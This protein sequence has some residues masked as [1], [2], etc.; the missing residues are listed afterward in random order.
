MSRFIKFLVIWP[1]PIHWP[2]QPSTHPPMDG[3]VSTNHKSS[4]RIELSQLGQDLFDLIPPIDPPI[5]PWVGVS[6]Q[7]IKLQTELNYLDWVNILKNFNALNLTPPIN[8]P[9]HQIIHPPMGGGF[10]TDFKSSNRIELSWL[11]QV[12]LNFYWFRWYPMGGGRWVD[13][14]RDGYGC[15]GGVPCIHTCTCTYACTC[16]L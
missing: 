7:I 11:V 3:G 2:T 10:S 4:N 13:W 14:G 5:H 8:P 16:M 1:D 15:V 12:L 9:T 6:L